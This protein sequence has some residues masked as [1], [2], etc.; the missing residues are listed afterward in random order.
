MGYYTIVH[1]KVNT[2]QKVSSILYE[3]IRVSSNVYVSLKKRN[4]NT[5]V[6]ASDHIVYYMFLLLLICHLSCLYAVTIVHVELCSYLVF[7]LSVSFVKCWY[8]FLLLLSCLFAR[9]CKYSKYLQP[10]FFEECLCLWRWSY[11]ATWTSS[12]CPSCGYGTGF[13]FNV[14]HMQV[15]AGE[16]Q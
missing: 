15:T 12:S 16:W 13:R 3:M 7:T 9:A 1:V 6:P 10:L 2:A 14:M 5:P 8:F 11:L 4:L